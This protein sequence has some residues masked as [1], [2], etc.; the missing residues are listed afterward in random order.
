MCSY[1]VHRNV[2]LRLKS[3]MGDLG[4]SVEKVGGVITEK[5]KVSSQ[6]CTK[7]SASSVPI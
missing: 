6:A 7:S 2:L 5:G 3:R 1:G 4:T